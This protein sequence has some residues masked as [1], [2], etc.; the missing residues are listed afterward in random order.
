MLQCVIL[1]N[2]IQ[3]KQ[4]SDKWSDRGKLWLLNMSKKQKTQRPPARWHP[5]VSR[6]QNNCYFIITGAH[7]PLLDLSV[8]KPGSYPN[9]D[10]YPSTTWGPRTEI[11]PDYQKF[12]SL[13]VW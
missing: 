9:Q 12:N 10:F 4:V 3:P 5:T 1:R 11:N 2:I 8:L 13:T 7:S 6:I